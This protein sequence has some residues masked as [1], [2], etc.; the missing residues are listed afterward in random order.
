MCMIVNVYKLTWHH[1]PHLIH[2]IHHSSLII[3]II[4][5]IIIII[6]VNSLSSSSTV[7]NKNCA[8]VAPPPFNS[9]KL[10][11]RPPP[12]SPD[13]QAC[14][15]WPRHLL[16]GSSWPGDQLPQLLR[17][18]QTINQS[19]NNHKST[20]NQSFFNWPLV[21]IDL[22]IYHVANVSCL[23]NNQLSS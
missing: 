20:L 11:L 22:T 14:F 9:F 17:A 12:A 6:Y 21:N 10:P 3:I 18:N 5:F 7:I 2:L 4:T 1:I 16:A 15:T 13:R 8:H 19:F 23:V